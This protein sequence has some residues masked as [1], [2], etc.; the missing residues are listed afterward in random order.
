MRVTRQTVGRWLQEGID[1]AEE[2]LAKISEITGRAAVWLRYGVA[3][4]NETFIERFVTG[5]EKA[6]EDMRD[7]LDRMQ[8]PMKGP[9]EGQRRAS[10]GKGPADREVRE[11]GGPLPKESNGE[12]KSG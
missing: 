9:G 5:Y 12:K 11:A 7:H 1:V 6:I 4:P 3:D 2:D 8:P 10:D